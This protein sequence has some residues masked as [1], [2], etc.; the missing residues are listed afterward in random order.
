MRETQVQID[1][2]RVALSEPEA[3]NG[4]MGTLAAASLAACAAVLL[5]GVMVLGPGVALEDGP[6]SASQTF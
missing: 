3:P 6:P 1:A 4:V 2:A 5:A